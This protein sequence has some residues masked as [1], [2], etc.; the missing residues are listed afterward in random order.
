[1]NTLKSMKI[2]CLIWLFPLFLNCSSRVSESS[3]LKSLERFEYATN[4][5]NKNKNKLSFQNS[6]DSLVLIIP[7]LKSEIDFFKKTF[8]L[9]KVEV[10][11]TKGGGNF[12]AAYYFE[13]EGESETRLIYSE[14]SKN[15]NEYMQF[16]QFADCA[17]TKKIKEN[18]AYS[19]QRNCN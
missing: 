14:D 10:N 3:L 17:T 16:E 2:Y 9:Q 11:S 15:L 5:I 4:I 1:M 6:S 12:C 7:E 13:D 18:W 19:K 8:G